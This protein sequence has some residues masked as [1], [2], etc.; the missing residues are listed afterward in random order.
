[1]RFR[2][3]YEHLTPGSGQVQEAVNDQIPHTGQEFGA[4]RVGIDL[5]Q[6]RDG[7]DQHTHREVAIAGADEGRKTRVD[8]DRPGQRAPLTKFDDARI[9]RTR[10][11]VPRLG[12]IRGHGED[13]CGERIIIEQSQLIVGC[14]RASERPA[15]P[16]LGDRMRHLL[17]PRQGHL[18][19]NRT[20]QQHIAKPDRSH[21]A[22]IEV[23]E[24]GTQQ[25]V[26]GRSSRHGTAIAHPQLGIRDRVK[27]FAFDD[28]CIQRNTGR[29]DPC[30][31]PVQAGLV[32]PALPV[33]EQLR[34]AT[35]HEVRTDAGDDLGDQ[36]VTH[37]TAI[38]VFIRR[39]PV[40][41]RGD[42]KRR[43]RHNALELLPCYGL[44]QVALANRNAHDCVQHRIQLRKRQRALRHIR[45]NNLSR[46][47]PRAKTLYPAS[48]ANVEHPLHRRRQLKSR[49]RHGCSAHTEHMVLGQRSA[50]GCLVEV[51]GDPPLSGAVV[52]H[53]RLRMHQHERLHEVALHSSKAQVNEPRDTHRRCGGCDRGDGLRIP[54]PK[55]PREHRNRS[56]V[57]GERPPSREG[58]PAAE[59]TV[60]DRPPQGADSLHGV[61]RRCKVSRESSSEGGVRIRGRLRGHASIQPA[62]SANPR[63]QRTGLRGGS[64]GASKVSALESGP[65]PRVLPV[66]GQP[67]GCDVSPAPFGA[68]TGV[69]APPA[70]VL[71]SHRLRVLRRP[72]RFLAALGI[73]LA[74]AVTTLAPA[75]AV[76][77]ESSVITTSTT[78]PSPSATP[79]PAS[80]ALAPLSAG[81]VAL[82]SE[83][84]ISTTVRG[85]ESTPLPAETGEISLGSAPLQTAAEI[86]AWLD[87]AQLPDTVTT[88]VIDRPVFPAVQEL[89]DAGVTTR[90]APESLATRAPGIY[91][92]E[93][94]VGS[95]TDRAVVTLL[96]AAGAV[97]TGVAVAV[98][99]TARP[100]VA[101]LLTAETLTTLT[102]ENGRLTR[103]LDGVAGSTAIIAVD[104]AILASIR[105][106]GTSAPADAL[107]WLERLEALPNERFAL[108][109]GD[110]DVSAQVTA[111]LPNLLKPT[112][113]AYAM[114]PLDHA[115]PGAT[116]TPSA[117][118]GTDESAEATA[119]ASPTPTPTASPDPLV[120]VLPDLDTLVA[121]ENARSEVYWPADGSASPEVAQTLTARAP[122]DTTPRTLVSSDSLT[123]AAPA[124][125]AGSVEDAGILIYDAATTDAFADVAAAT[126]FDRG[127]PLAELAARVWLSSSTATGPL[128]VASDR[129]GAV[130]EFGVSAAVAAVR[131][132]PG[133]RPTSLAELLTAEPAAI[134]LAPASDAVSE[135]AVALGTLQRDADSLAAFATVLEDPTQI[136]ARERTSIL[137]LLGAGWSGQ[138]SWS[139]ALTTHATDTQATLASVQIRPLST[140][141]LFSSSAQLYV[142]V[143]NDLPWPARLVLTANPD[144]LRLDVDRVIPFV[145]EPGVNSRVLIPVRARVGSGEVTLEVR[146]FSE[147]YEPIGQPQRAEVMVRAEWEGIGLGILISVVAGLLILGV[148]R[149]ILRL[150]KRRA[151]QAS[152]ASESTEEIEGDARG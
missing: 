139:T 75:S 4:Q 151:A 85:G 2:L 55:K 58:M 17:V 45:R 44:K 54:E 92:L 37:A 107:A 22:R 121:V 80:L 39:N 12:D 72:G 29:I 64:P 63:T 47:A 96:P 127:A 135:R 144:D 125:A 41:P 60:G 94:T 61:S 100:Q 10:Q 112:S 24:P 26:V 114:A 146:L 18:A 105:V 28:P 25:L 141:Q 110:A 79:A 74:M 15:E 23:I 66:L 68:P 19:R 134:E 106:L 36:G 14:E 73:G 76:V 143:Q 140:I 116:P 148:I 113:L 83:L 103:I 62:L 142:Y 69:A 48:G 57:T 34:R 109:F 138:T 87:E 27:F 120:P 84:T 16:T 9:L 67:P 20:T 1:M 40:D 32:A 123:A 42:H 5:E 11:Q 99:V 7:C 65:V 130:S 108:Q 128:L 46:P 97:D 137:Q 50:E 51:A 136:T 59:S 86:T 78:T 77:P 33:S 102:A 111:G 53:K 35:R 52:I 70:G 149:T 71:S 6:L 122:D 8:R 56:R 117:T 3:N 49:K 118:P 150:R 119:S 104:P 82:G 43:V 31:H 133:V 147:T 152:G 13:G 30:P 89:V 145:A 90:V 129:L 91:A 81:V 98:A 132:I 115:T 126:D 101:G 131:A 95:L 88:D 124:Q 38:T 93:A 21:P